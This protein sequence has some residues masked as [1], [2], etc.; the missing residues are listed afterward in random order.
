MHVQYDDVHNST[1][2]WAS[3]LHPLPKPFT[4]RWDSQLAMP[5]HLLHHNA[6]EQTENIKEAKDDNCQ[7]KCYM[8]SM[9]DMQ[10][11]DWGGGGG[12]GGGGGYNVMAKRIRQ[13]QK[14]V[15]VM[16]NFHKTA[17]FPSSLIRMIRENFPRF[18]LV[19]HVRLT[20]FDSGSL[21]NGC[22]CNMLSFH[23][24][25]LHECHR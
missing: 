10:E 8:K 19:P 23:P 15:N 20:S 12:G 16:A 14:D 9:Q 11:A 2:E 6:R 7:L 1:C 5:S 21:Q 22:T 25:G 17:R 4:H 13:E 3:A 24:H 18:T